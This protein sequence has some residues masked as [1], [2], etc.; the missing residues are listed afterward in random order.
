MIFFLAFRNLWRRPQ[1]TILSLLSIAIVSGLLIFM[2]SFQVGVY[3]TMKQSTLRIFDG[4]A[5]FQPP[6]YAD[7][8]RLDRTIANPTSIAGLAQSVS[9]IT[10]VSPRINGF[11]VLANGG[12]SYAAAVVGVDPSS[13]EK[14]SSIAHVIRK[15]RYL[16]ASDSAAA[17]IGALLA[18]NL[19]LSTGSRVTLLGSAKDGSVATDVLE[20]KGIY[21]S[22][23]PELDRSIL[24]MPFA[25]AETTFGMN[26]AANTIALGGP[27][28]SDVNAALPALAAI[29][30]AHGLALLDWGNLE[31]ALRDNLRLKYAT[32]MLFYSTLVAVVA[33]IVLNTLLMSVL[34]RT[35]EFGML[36]AIG[37]RPSKIGQM[38][39]SELLL[40]AALGTG[41][42]V[43]AG[44][45]GTLWLEH[46]GVLIPQFS[47]VLRQFGLP[48]R[49]Y[50]ELSLFSGLFGPAAIFAAILLGGLVPYARVR[51]LTAA[52]AM[53]AN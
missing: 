38:V 14:I 13:E 25:R 12:R 37:M 16:Q 3:E 45:S 28:L 1:R 8:P 22:G 41:L 39:W 2:L 5:Q 6:D 18:R 43:A 23:V 36:L 51:S 50:P 24:E 15:G 9:G 17:V 46:V 35:R 47:D 19:G 48:Q 7:D 11:A 29:A 52:T 53:R 21:E 40:L 49:L 26:N 20:V 42:G 27:T 33:F 31:P 10:A 32:S 44:I 34:E 4:Y 30:H